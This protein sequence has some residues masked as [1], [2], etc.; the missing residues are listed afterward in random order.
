MFPTSK[1]IVFNILRIISKL[2]N[3][4]SVCLKLNEKKQFIKTL[5]S[6]FKFYKNDIHIIIRLAFI[7]A[8]M[9]SY[10]ADI[11]NQLYFDFGAWQDIFVCFDYYATI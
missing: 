10:L 3:Y 6:F 9:T 5:T 4:E 8:N 2:S 1:N 11:R 7:F